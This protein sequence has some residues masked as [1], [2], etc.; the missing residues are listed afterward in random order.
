ME[1]PGAQGRPCGP[2][3]PHEGPQDSELDLRGWPELPQLLPREAKGDESHLSGKQFTS[4]S[5]N[6]AGMGRQGSNQKCGRSW[7]SK[8]AGVCQEK[9]EAPPV[10]VNRVPGLQAAFGQPLGGGGFSPRG[11]ARWPDQKPQHSPADWEC[12]LRGAGWATASM[13]ACFLAF[14]FICLSDTPFYTKRP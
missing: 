12:R 2:P 1:A 11:R 13:W 7:R 8:G 9:G 5:L 10:G 14:S 4:K 3:R 6:C